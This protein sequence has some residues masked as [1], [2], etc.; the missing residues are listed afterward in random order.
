MAGAP[1]EAAALARRSVHED[2]I[3][4]ASYYAMMKEWSIR[5]SVPI[6]GVGLDARPSRLIV[7]SCGLNVAGLGD[8]A[9]AALRPGGLLGRHRAD[10]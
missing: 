2:D 5:S 10:I 3:E 7:P 1:I 6:V 4:Q 8:G 9:D